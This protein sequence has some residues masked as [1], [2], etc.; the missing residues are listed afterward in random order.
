[1]RAT[2]PIVS[3][4]HVFIQHVSE[5]GRTRYDIALEHVYDSHFFLAYVEFMTLLPDPRTDDG[6]YLLRSVRALINPPRGWLRG[7]L[8]QRIKR[9]MREQLAEDMAE[10]KRALEAAA[11]Q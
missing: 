6:F 9:A 7:I 2:R 3:I 11:A 8:L 4:V 5:G 10:T 1:M